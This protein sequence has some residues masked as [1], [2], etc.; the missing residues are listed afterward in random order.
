MEDR[1]RSIDDER[2]RLHRKRKGDEVF[3]SEAGSEVI[4]KS[5]RTIRSRKSFCCRAVAS[6]FFFSNFFASLR[7]CVKTI[8]RIISV[9]VHAKTQ[10]RKVEDGRIVDLN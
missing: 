5:G 6:Y 9:G 10:R 3:A 4:M 1:E 7:L 2:S 8:V